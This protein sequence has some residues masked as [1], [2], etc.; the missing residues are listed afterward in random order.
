[1]GPAVL[2]LALALAFAAGDPGTAAGAAGAGDPCAP[3]GPDGVP[4]RAC[5]APG[6]GLMV[7]VGGAGGAGGGALDLRTVALFRRDSRG[8]ETATLQW[9]S[10]QAA[11]DAAAR[12]THGEVEEAR[13]TLWTGTFVRHLAEPFLLV[14][15]PRP[16]RLPFPFDVGVR[17]E[18]VGAAWRRDAERELE[19]VPLRA[20]LLL[21]VVRHRAL[22]RLAVGPEASWSTRLSRDAAPLHRV[23]P[24][25]AGVLDARFDTDDGLWAVALVTRG[26]ASLRAGGGSRAFADGALSI[27]RTVVAVND[28]PVAGYVEGSFGTGEGAFRGARVSAGLRLGLFR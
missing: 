27:E 11:L 18:G 10:D 16:V 5:F 15:G 25:T 4:F 28:R 8:G 21:D 7:G 26:G 6:Q 1:M 24:F 23:A 20:A 22:R 3:E 13:A 14:P 17:F 9:L 2:P 19:L 12:F